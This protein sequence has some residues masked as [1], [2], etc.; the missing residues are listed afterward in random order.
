MR[1]IVAET[2]R[3][4]HEGVGMM[5]LVVQPLYIAMDTGLTMVTYAAEPRS[6]SSERLLQLAQQ[7]VMT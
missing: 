5:S 4:R 2:K 3:I 1:E 6:E 7:T